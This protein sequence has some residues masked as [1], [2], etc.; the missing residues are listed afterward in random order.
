MEDT[1]IRLLPLT[2]SLLCMAVLMSAG[3]VA[4]RAGG[5]SLPVSAGS[6]A[7]VVF[8]SA[9]TRSVEEPLTRTLKS[10]LGAVSIN[11]SSP[12]G[13]PG[14]ND[15]Q[16]NEN[17]EGDGDNRNGKD[18]DRDHDHDHDK[19]PTPSPEPSTVLSFGVALLIGGG[20]LLLGRMR[21]T[22]K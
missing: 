8:T 22:R 7:E 2:Q 4:V 5:A 16:G 21:E 15:H 6:A 20:V 1:M 3:A 17:R 13:W 9:V 12:T 10:S 11:W 19:P 18:H 14:D